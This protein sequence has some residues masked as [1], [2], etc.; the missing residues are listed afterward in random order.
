MQDVLLDRFID[1]LIVIGIFAGK[2]A[3]AYVG[4]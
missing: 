2:V 4:F 3:I 1:G